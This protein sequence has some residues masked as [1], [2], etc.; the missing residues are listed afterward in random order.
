MEKKGVWRMTR[1]MKMTLA[2]LL[3]AL[4]ALAA[5]SFRHNAIKEEQ[6]PG[7]L[8]QETEGRWDCG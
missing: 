5:V 4:L 6:E 3:A 7:F 1:E 2:A 8:V